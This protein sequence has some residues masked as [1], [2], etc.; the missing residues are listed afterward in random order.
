LTSC[1]CSTGKFHPIEGSALDDVV[2][3]EVDD[4]ED[5]EEE[6]D[7]DNEQGAGVFMGTA[8]VFKAATVFAFFVFFDPRWCV[9]GCSSSESFSSTALPESLN[10][11]F[12]GT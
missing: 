11:D 10:S 8:A 2:A 1:D 7:E 6:E 12:A 3:D 4:D 5:E 9:A